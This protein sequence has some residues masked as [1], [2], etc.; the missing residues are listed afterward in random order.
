M[1]MLGLDVK[2]SDQDFQYLRRTPAARNIREDTNGL[3]RIWAQPDHQRLPK[4]VL[5]GDWYRRRTGAVPRRRVLAAALLQVVT[6]VAVRRNARPQHR[7][8]REAGRRDPGGG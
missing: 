8:Q 6:G 4:A 3:H 7:S 1:R 2:V 5:F